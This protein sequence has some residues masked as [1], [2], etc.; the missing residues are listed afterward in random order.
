MIPQKTVVI[1]NLSTGFLFDPVQD[2]S[3]LVIEASALFHKVRDLLVGIHNRGVVAV[4]KKLANFRKGQVGLLPDQIHGN[5]PGLGHG[6][7]ARGPK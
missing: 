7:L 5:L 1:H 2:L 3:D 6:L 4:A